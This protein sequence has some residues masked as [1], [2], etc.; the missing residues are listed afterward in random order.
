MDKKKEINHIVNNIIKLYTEVKKL[1]KNY[2]IYSANFHNAVIQ[3]RKEKSEEKEYQLEIKLLKHRRKLD[4]VNKNISIK[5]NKEKIKLSNLTTVKQFEKY[6]QDINNKIKEDWDENPTNKYS[7]FYVKGI[8]LSVLNDYLLDS[9][10]RQRFDIHDL[11]KLKTLDD[12]KRRAEFMHS[13]F[14]TKPSV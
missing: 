4:K 3:A 10:E 12:I 5:I 2:T 14:G 11:S 13:I 7:N 9:L 1:Y 6:L 8:N